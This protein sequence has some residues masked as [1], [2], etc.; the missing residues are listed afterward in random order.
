M[1]IGVLVFITPWCAEKL[2]AMTHNLGAKD[3]DKSWE[4]L[5]LA[6]L[7]RISSGSFMSDSSGQRLNSWINFND[8]NL[9]SV[10]NWI[11]KIMSYVI[12][13]SRSA[14]IFSIFQIKV[15]RHYVAITAA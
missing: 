2:Y 9:G 4:R 11:L 7:K 12:E 5:E 10:I 15:D 14:W 3:S 6:T 8:C 1:S 13:L